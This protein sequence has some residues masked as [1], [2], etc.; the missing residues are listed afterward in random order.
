[1]VTFELNEMWEQPGKDMH[2]G[3]FRAKKDHKCSST[4]ADWKTEKRR[5]VRSAGLAGG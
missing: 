4:E 2:Y 5:E 1:M 3:V